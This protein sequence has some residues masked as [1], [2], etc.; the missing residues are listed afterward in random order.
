M[1]DI[2]KKNN[3]LDNYGILT[4]QMPED[5]PRYDFKLIREYCKKHNKSLADMSETEIE[6]F[7]SN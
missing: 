6:R 4:D 7:R 1:N 5:A 2:I 3:A